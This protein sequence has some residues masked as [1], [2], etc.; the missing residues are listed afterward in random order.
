M[1]GWNKRYNRLEKGHPHSRNPL[2]HPGISCI[3]A[4][5]ALGKHSPNVPVPIPKPERAMEGVPSPILQKEE[6][7]KEEKE[8]NDR[9]KARVRSTWFKGNEI[10]H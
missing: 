9:A 1:N 10:E 2:K 7:E 8:E 6:Q 5:A 4:G 3:A